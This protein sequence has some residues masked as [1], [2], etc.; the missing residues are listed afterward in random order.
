MMLKIGVAA[1][2]ACVLLTACGGSS[3]VEG[4]A[5]LVGAKFDGPDKVA[6]ALGGFQR[7]SAAIVGD[8]VTEAASKAASFDG[9]GPAY[10]GSMGLRAKAT[11]TTACD[12]G[13]STFT[14]DTSTLFADDGLLVDNN[15]R[16]NF[17]DAGGNGS[18]ARNGRLND[19]C[20]DG[21]QTADDCNAINLRFAD[22]PTGN[23][24][25]DVTA[26]GSFDGAPL[27]LELKLKGD[28]TQTFSESTDVTTLS[29]TLGINDRRAKVTA[30]AL[31]ENFR[32]VT[33]S[34]GET[35]E[36]SFGF[37]SSKSNCAIGRLT[38]RTDSPLVSDDDG[39]TTAGRL[40]VTDGSGTAARVDFNSDGSVTVTLPNGQVKTFSETQLAALC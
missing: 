31:F 38:V 10:R 24:T 5:A 4:S 21:A 35:Y 40:I 14:D 17:S 2:A 7:A 22:G 37:S 32:V 27:D 33:T 34:T 26:I 30:T 25:F 36:G 19:K 28:I 6:G 15:C 16:T 12:S 11:T 1:V 39:R 13:T 9:R 3:D 29:A 23:A 20:T 18:V 8:D